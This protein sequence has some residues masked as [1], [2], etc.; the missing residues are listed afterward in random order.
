MK[1]KIESSNYKRETNSNKNGQNWTQWTKLDRMDQ[2]G[3]KWTMR[4]DL[5]IVTKLDHFDNLDKN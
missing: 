2:S 5:D 1:N 3:L 4:T